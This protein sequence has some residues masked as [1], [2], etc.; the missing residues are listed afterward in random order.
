MIEIR[1]CWF[2]VLRQVM[3]TS[4]SR[5]IYRSWD[6]PQPSCS[7]LSIKPCGSTAIFISSGVSNSLCGS[8][9]CCLFVWLFMSVRRTTWTTTIKVRRACK[10]ELWTQWSGAHGDHVLYFNDMPVEKSRGSRSC[11]VVKTIHG[12][13]IANAAVFFLV[14]HEGQRTFSLRQG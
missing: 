6:V 12:H 4:G 1:R 11:V 9:S 13:R 8:G 14:Q 3:L 2:E 10:T 5:T 7:V